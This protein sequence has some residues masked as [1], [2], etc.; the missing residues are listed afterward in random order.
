MMIN[1]PWAWGNLD[2]ERHQVRRRAAADPE[3]SAGQRPSSA[4]SVPPSRRQPEQDLAIAVPRKLPA[5]RR[6]SG[7]SVNA[8]KPL[9]AVAK[10]PSED[11]GKRTFNIKA[12]MQNAQNGEPIT[13]R[14]RDEP[15]LVLLRN[16]PQERH[17]WS[18]GVDEA[19]DTAAKRIVQ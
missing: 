10:S 4:C 15:F 9:G 13:V 3:G 7:T 16:C 2:K 1:G 12:T 18:S 8:D 5:D 17:L 11:P 14:A 19:L 6:R